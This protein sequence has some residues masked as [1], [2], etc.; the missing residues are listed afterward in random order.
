MRPISLNKFW[1]AALAASLSAAPAAATQWLNCANAAQGVDVGLLLGT[2]GGFG[3]TGA[4]MRQEDHNWST[5][6]AYG[7]GTPFTIGQ[8]FSD[9]SG[10][11]VDFYDEI[12]NDL[13][14]ELRL[15]R[16]AEGDDVVLAGMLRIVGIGVWPVTCDWE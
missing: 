12:V 14:A 9:S 16:G 3:A 15:V 2:A 8:G 5:D 10:M 11:K 7:A 4:I 13:V 1:L 6:P